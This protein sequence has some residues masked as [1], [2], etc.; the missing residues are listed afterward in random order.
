[1]VACRT[2]CENPGDGELEDSVADLVREI[3][4]GRLSG[5][6]HDC[7]EEALAATRS[8]KEIVVGRELRW[9]SKIQSS[10]T[11][12][13]AAM[14]GEAHMRSY[15][16]DSEA[17]ILVRHVEARTLLH[18]KEIREQ[19]SGLCSFTCFSQYWLLGSEQPNIYSHFSLAH[20]TA[21][22][23]LKRDKNQCEHYHTSGSET[24]H[25]HRISP[26]YFLVHGPHYVK[27]KGFVHNNTNVTKQR[28]HQP[29]SKRAS[30]NN[31][32][33]IQN[34]SWCSPKSRILKA[35]QSLP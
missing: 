4:E 32:I 34:S 26:I 29:V 14:Q 23:C 16:R 30:M 15:F 13:E 27:L 28:S 21:S 22:Y 10:L 25:V 33:Q 9:K 3:S 17:T 6:H 1:M 5:S 20:E 19:L 11:G 8:G 7:G 2:N 18:V 31:A 12:F 24:A 35:S